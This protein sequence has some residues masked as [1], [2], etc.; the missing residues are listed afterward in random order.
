MIRRPEELAESIKKSVNSRAVIF[1]HVVL[2][3]TIAFHTAYDPTS[4]SFEIILASILSITL[5]LLILL[6]IFDM[7]RVNNR[8]LTYIIFYQLFVFLG[9]GFISAASTPYVMGVYLVVFVS[10]L[11]YGAKGVWLTVACFGVTSIAKYIYLTNTDHI[12]QTD[13]L[14]I[15]VAFFVFAAICSLYINYQRVFDWDREKLKDTIKSEA[16]EQKRLVALVNNM[17]E[18]VLVL[19]EKQQVRMYNAAA[20]ALFDTNVSLINK[21]V[22]D[23]AKLEDEKEVSVSMKDLLP[24]GSKPVERHD[25]KIRYGDNDVASLSIVVTP[26]RPNYGYDSAE[27]GYVVTVRDITREKSLEDERDEF[28]SVISHELRTP[29]TVVEAGVSNSILFA[30]KLAGG[31][32]VVASLKTAHD[33]SVFL[34]TMLNDLSTFARA[35]KDSLE[36]LLEDINPREIISN[37]KDSYQAGAVEKG[38]KI[39]SEIDDSTPESIVSNRLYVREILQNF[40]SNS[41]KYSDKGVITLKAKEQDGGVLFSLSDQGIGISVSNQKKVFDKF[42]RAEDFRTRSSSGTG[43]GLYITKKLAKLLDAKLGLESE[44]GKGS[45]FSIF[46]PSKKTLLENKNEEASKK[47]IPADKV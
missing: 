14:N 10:N 40:M 37:L 17:T 42:F 15:V 34:A 12:G 22:D 41:M 32:K 38:L 46:V 18:G 44:V 39:E 24:E 2:A 25:I 29:V 11:Y 16:I 23:F 9:I 1:S 4:S 3:M 47:E 28:I 31:K 5:I 30:E 13:K 7:A 19:D 43:L 36:M 8:P 20:L 45:T 35:E 6:R 21:N 33:Q 27:A 26:I